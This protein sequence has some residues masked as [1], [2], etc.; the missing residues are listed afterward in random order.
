MSEETERFFDHVVFGMNG[1]FQDLLTQPIGFVNA[2][3]A[4]LYGLN[5]DAFGAELEL[6]ELDAAERPGFLTRVGFLASHAL[7]DRASPILRGAYIQEQVLCVDIPAPPPEAEGT[8]LPTEGLATNRERV[9]AQTAAASCAGCHHTLINPTGFALESFSAAGT[10]QTEE[11]GVPIDTA[12]TVPLGADSVSVSGST[13]LMAALATS[14]QAQYC[15]AYKWVE[16]AYGRAV[17]PA[18]A[19]VVNDVAAKLADADYSI[20]DLVVDLTQ[21][22]SFRYRA[23][24][25][26]VAQ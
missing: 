15:Y 11:N 20:L 2:A 26:E 25:T 8:P 23:L 22:P 14:P 4:P 12:A 1:S 6:V 9:D 13:E 10:H 18:D 3:L 5:A 24:D 17:T 16:Y 7:Y 21:S 19:C